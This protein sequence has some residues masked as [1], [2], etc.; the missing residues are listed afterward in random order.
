MDCP[1]AGTAHPLG[2]HHQLILPPAAEVPVATCVRWQRTGGLSFGGKA[3]HPVIVR[4]YISACAAAG[5]ALFSPHLCDA[6]AG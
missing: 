3:P 6:D 2:R 1:H 4:L 5:I